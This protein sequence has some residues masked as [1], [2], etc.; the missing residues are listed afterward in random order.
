VHVYDYLKRRLLFKL[1]AGNIRRIQLVDKESVLAVLESFGGCDQ[2][3]GQVKLYSIKVE[4]YLWRKMQADKQLAFTTEAKRKKV[5]NDKR[6]A[7]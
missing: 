7:Q 4:T 1:S 2:D 6:R 3:E 5:M